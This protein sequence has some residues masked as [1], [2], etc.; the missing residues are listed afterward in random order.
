MTGR[1]TRR[2]RPRISTR[3]EDA[4]L[5]LSGGLAVAFVLTGPLGAMAVAPRL[6]A[7]AAAALLGGGGG[8]VWRSA[9]PGATP[10]PAEAVAA[11]WPVAREHRIVAPCSR[12]SRSPASASSPPPPPPSSRPG[13]AGSPWVPPPGSPPLA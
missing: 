7:G 1:L 6:F 13:D 4:A 5:V 12:S 9:T 3:L 10:R 8:R 2:L 11:D